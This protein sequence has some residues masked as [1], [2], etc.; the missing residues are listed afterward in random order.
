MLRNPV[1]VE[2]LP[3]R[4]SAEIRSRQEALRTIFPPRLDILYHPNFGFLQKRRV[5]QHPPLLSTPAARQQGL[6]QIGAIVR[7]RQYDNDTNSSNSDPYSADGWHRLD[8]LHG[9]CPCPARDR[10]REFRPS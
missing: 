6:S 8:R 1:A 10:D 4:K 2:K 5:F 3:S 9:L 7:C